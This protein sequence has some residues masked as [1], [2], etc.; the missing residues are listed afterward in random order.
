[1]LQRRTPAIASMAQANS[2]S[3]KD[4][5]MSFIV[6]LL[7]ESHSLSTCRLSKAG[8]NAKTLYFSCFHLV[9]R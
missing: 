7:C 8:A 9:L 4:F 1:M 3:P 5:T 6:S 2:R